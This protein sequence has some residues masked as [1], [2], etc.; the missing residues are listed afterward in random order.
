M[1][2]LLERQQEDDRL[3]EKQL[4]G[5]AQRFLVKCLDL[6][7]L[8]LVG[9]VDVFSASDLGQERGP[10]SQQHD[11]VRLR[12]E[13]GTDDG[14]QAGEQC[15]QGSDPSPSAGFAEESTTD[16][17]NGRTEERRSGED[18]HSETPLFGGEEIC[19]GSTEKRRTTISP[20]PS[21]LSHSD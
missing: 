1:A 11:R 4:P 9:L 6:D 10:T 16:R 21:K 8:S 13:K 14:E 3:L 5:P 15:D 18:G 2:D 20:F 19:D 17:T 7:V 12:E